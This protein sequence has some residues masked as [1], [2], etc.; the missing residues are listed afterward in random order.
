[1]LYECLAGEPP[2]RRA[3]EAETLWAHM[4]DE[5]RPLPGG[6]GIDQVLTR[7]LAKEPRSRYATCAELIEAARDGLGLSR[8]ARPARTAPPIASGRQRR[9]AWLLVAGGVL[10]LAAALTAG[11]ASLGG[12]DGDELEAVG[13]GVAAI[14]AGE[15]RIA[16]FTETATGPSNVA[17]GRARYG[18]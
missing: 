15:P 1:M 14:D 18:S 6:H 3:T 11:L 8:G 12:G 2:F 5:P 17:V 4:Q 10:M 9:G 13:N 7:G 16:S